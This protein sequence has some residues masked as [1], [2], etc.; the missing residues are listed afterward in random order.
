MLSLPK[1]CGPLLDF[2]SRLARFPGRTVR[3]LTTMSRRGSRL[4]TTRSYSAPGQPRN[5]LD[6]RGSVRV[7]D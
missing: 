3:L 7:G 6:F 5:L 1:S 4:A 2:L